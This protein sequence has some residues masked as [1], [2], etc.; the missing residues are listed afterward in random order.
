MLNE[1]HFELI[2]PCENQIA[3]LYEL[4]KKR[5]HSISHV[6]LPSYSEHSAFVFNHPYR[7]WYLVCTNGE[8]IGAFYITTENTVGINLLQHSVAGAGDKIIDYVL[9]KYS[10][11]PALKSKR[12]G[13]FS[14]NVS[15]ENNELI[16]LL[17]D[18]NA[19]LMQLSY[20]L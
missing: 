14:I 9:R 15:P 16:Q 3:Q 5:V 2:K 17:K 19:K 7:A 18:R 10:P 4:L 1:I 12:A 8:C 20:A 11:L 6:D 13:G